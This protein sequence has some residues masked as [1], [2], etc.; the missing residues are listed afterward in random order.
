[1][2]LRPW[3]NAATR[4]EMN[5]GPVRAGTAETNFYAGIDAA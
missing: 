5:T 4:H 2:Y 3:L 1:M